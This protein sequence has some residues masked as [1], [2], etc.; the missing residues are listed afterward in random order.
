M[1]GTNDRVLRGYAV[2]FAIAP[3]AAPAGA[4][5]AGSFGDEIRWNHLAGSTTVIDYGHGAAWSF[6]T[7]A[8]RAVNPAVANG[9]PTGTPGILNLDGEEF[10][11]GLASLVLDFQAAGSAAFSGPLSV[12]S[13]TD[14][15]LHPLDA[16]L[17]QAGAPVRTKANFVVWNENEVKFSGAYRC[18]TC[19]DQTLLS[20]YADEGSP[21]PTPVFLLPVLQTDHGKAVIEGV[22]GIACSESVSASLLGVSATMLTF[23]PGRTAYGGSTLVGRGDESA[24]I[25]WSDDAVVLGACCIGSACLEGETEQS[26]SI[27]GGLFLGIGTTCAGVECRGACCAVDGA[28]V[29]GLTIDE[30][31]SAG[32]FFLGAGTN[33]LGAVCPCPGDLSGDG[34]IGFSELLEILSHWGP[35]SGC[36]YDLDDDGQVGFSDLLFILSSWGPCS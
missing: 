28:C 3:A 15:T 17:R 10:A 20:L 8:A 27:E 29:D 22:S 7:W 4:E 24:R 18:V 34:Q 5:S 14:L 31:A 13:D 30:C 25:I 23:G 33:C 11:S 2:A 36:P 1:D 19:W 9:E 12:V 21:P 35:C 6:P 32:G 16:D 26:C